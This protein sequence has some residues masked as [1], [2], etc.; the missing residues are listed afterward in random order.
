VS[1]K[2]VAT[3]ATVVLVTVQTVL[4]VVANAV[5]SVSMPAQ[6]QAAIS[7]LTAV[8]AALLLAA[9]DLA[10]QKLAARHV[11]LPPSPEGRPVHDCGF[12][13]GLR[14]GDGTSCAHCGAVLP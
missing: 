2:S 1:V 8:V 3:E 7:I 14:T 13:D 4:T 5:S 9:K 12:Y 11:T 10:G 6:V